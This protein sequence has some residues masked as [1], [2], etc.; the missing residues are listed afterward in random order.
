MAKAKATVHGAISLVN[1]IA[2]QKGATL[3]IAL[4]VEAIVETSSGKGISIQSKNK[5]LSSRLINKTVEKIIPKRD[6]D[7][8]KI[9]ITLDSEIPTGYGLKSSSAISSAVVT[10]SKVLVLFHLQ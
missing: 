6:L 5:S 2:N 10:D 8:N 9:T 4:K 7:K 1:A 3:G